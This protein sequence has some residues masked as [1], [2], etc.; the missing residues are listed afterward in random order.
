MQAYNHT[1]TCT[2]AY[3][4]A[5]TGFSGKALQVWLFA[6]HV[7]GVEVRMPP[8]PWTQEALDRT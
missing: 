3:T 5:H 8:S 2:H 7:L 6:P 4:H 1:H